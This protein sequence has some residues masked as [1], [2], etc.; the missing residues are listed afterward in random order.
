MAERHPRAALTRRGPPSAALPRF[1]QHPTSSLPPRNGYDLDVTVLRCPSAL[2]IPVMIAPSAESTAPQHRHG[3]GTTG[4]LAGHPT[5]RTDRKPVP[6]AQRGKDHQP[7][8]RPVKPRV[9]A[10]RWKGRWA[11]G[12]TPVLRHVRAHSPRGRGQWPALFLQSARVGHGAPLAVRMLEPAAPWDTYAPH[13]PDRGSV[14][15]GI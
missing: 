15:R 8:N 5:L 12:S 6:L 2:D 9:C 4:W 14:N 10:L 1:M 3:W 11:I 7:R 13:H